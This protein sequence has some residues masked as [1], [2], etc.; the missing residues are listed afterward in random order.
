M[1]GRNHRRMIV[2]SCVQPAEKKASG[3]GGIG[4]VPVKRFQ[5]DKE[6]PSLAWGQPTEGAA[7]RVE[8]VQLLPS[9][10]GMGTLTATA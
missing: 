7:F 3:S 1:T 10:L 8:Q 4:L 5:P 9:P 2:C 6:R